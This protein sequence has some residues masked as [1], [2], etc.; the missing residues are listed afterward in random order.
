MKMLREEY[1][2]EKRGHD[3]SLIIREG[4]A[5]EGGEIIES[6]NLEVD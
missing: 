4:K 6:G 1:W 5:R 3:E 2:I